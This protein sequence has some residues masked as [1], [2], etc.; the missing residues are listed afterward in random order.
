MSFHHV[1]GGVLHS[2]DLAFPALPPAEPQTPTWTLELAR[3]DAVDG[4][5]AGDAGFRLV[6]EEPAGTRNVRAYRAARGYRIEYLDDTG[7]FDI[8]EDGSRIRWRPG[9]SPNL[10]TVR[11]SVVGKVLPMALHAGGG[12]CLHGSAVALPEGVVAFVAPKHHGKS[13]LAY[14]LVQ[15]GAR[16]ATDDAV[17]LTIGERPVAHPGVFSIRLWDDSARQLLSAEDAVSRS[18]AGKTVLT[19]VADERVMT[20]SAPLAAIYALRPVSAERAT[21]AVTRERLS[22]RDAVL[23]LVTHTKI[24]SLLSPLDAAGSFSKL[25][26]VTAH[27]PVYTLGVV[28]DFG[29]LREVAETVIGWHGG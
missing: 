18:P 16:L 11:I 28:R 4:G 6:A 26:S 10:E 25:S 1:F 2:P 29:R 17:P 19:S 23:T 9:A 22:P 12:V 5:D 14:A 27:V 3:E 15:A 20:E 8:S 13:S 7:R 21:A 24:G